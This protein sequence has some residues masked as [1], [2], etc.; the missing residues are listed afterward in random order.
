MAATRAELEARKRQLELQAEYLKIV[1]D[2][3]H[4]YFNYWHIEH[5]PGSETPGFN[6][7]SRDRE[8]QIEECKRLQEAHDA[9]RK[10]WDVR[11][12][13]RQ[14]GYTTLTLAMA[15][16]CA[17]FHPGHSWLYLSQDED[18]ANDAIRFNIKPALDRLPDWLKERGGQP[19]GDRV[20]RVIFVHT[21]AKG[22]VVET[23]I[24]SLSTTGNTGRSR[25]T[26][27]AILDEA[28]RNAEY[29]AAF[30]SVDKMTYGPIF[31]F[32]TANG[33]GNWFHNIWLDSQRDDSV[34]RS[35][36][37][38]WW[39][40]PGR[41]EEWYEEQKRAHRDQLH[42]FYAEYP[43]TPEEAFA[44][45][46][47]P[48]FS[49][50]L[51][52]GQH[53]C[54]APYKYIWDMAD[55]KWV[56]FEGDETPLDALVLNVW[57]KPW[58]KSEANSHGFATPNYVLG[59]DPAEGLAHGDFTVFKVINTNTGEEAAAFRGKPDLDDLADML[60]A[61]GR[62]YQNAL[63]G[64]E[65]NAAGIKPIEDLRHKKY[66][67]QYR[68]Q[69]FLTPGRGRQKRYGYNTNKHTKA[70][71]IGDMAEALKKGE[72]LLH[73]PNF[74]TEA[75]TFVSNGKG[76]FEAVK[77]KND[78]VVMATLIT[79]AMHLEAP[80]Y[81]YVEPTEPPPKGSFEDLYGTLEEILEYLERID[82]QE[83][84]I[85]PVGTGAGV[86]NGL[87]PKHMR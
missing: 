67:R 86:P 62:M 38:P 85:R 56:E 16:W 82:G 63:I 4:F 65:A 24:I 27:G 6:L 48:A 70:K 17:K 73:D 11:L 75:Q 21:D 49:A 20:D 66:P 30:N 74:R 52:E 78:D 22:K 19:K 72:V 10:T 23:P 35:G 71:M 44:K 18:S 29:G 37:W 7:P 2:F 3:E 12:K 33:M 13:A 69:K 14:I 25:R 46:G 64:I 43:A 55:R 40:V 32:S 50:E 61:T 51:L 68:G 45:S 39:V 9:G 58:T 15:A 34:W 77:G 81:P 36:F 26:F 57:Q 54:E 41:S 42:E 1:S 47:L 31:V 76:S 53:F 5:P 79:W 28:A 83:A 87:P 59:C 80:D 8:Y 84:P 60:Y